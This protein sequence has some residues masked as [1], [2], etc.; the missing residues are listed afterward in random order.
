[1]HYYERN[2]AEIKHEYT[3]FLIHIISPLIYEGIK[4]MYKKAVET[5]LKFKELAKQN[6]NVNN[7]GILKLFQHFLKNIPTLN[8]TLIES[9]MIRIRD[10]SKHAD[11]FEKLIKAV[12]KSHIIL[13]TF[14][15]SGKKCK[16][17]NDKIHEQIDIKMFI[18]KIYIE[19]A[20]QIYNSPELFWHEFSS[21]EI[22]RNQRECM[23]IINKAINL[24]IKESIPM[25][26]VLTEFLK[27]DYIEETYQQKIDNIKNMLNKN[28]E[29]NINYFDDDD[30]KDEKDD[31][32][33]ESFQVRPPHS[34]SDIVETKNDNWNLTTWVK[35]A[36]RYSKGMGNE[37]KID[38]Y[39]YNA[40]PTIPLPEGQLFF[41]NNTKFD[42]ECCPATYSSSRG[43]ACLS[44]PQYNHL[45][46]RGG[47]NTPPKNTNTSYFNEF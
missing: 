25:N 38:S 18:H 4:S 42:S 3:D 20:R 35:N 37:N 1:M 40:G 41:F 15:A 29:D 14:N 33:T 6:A 31:D 39:K 27:N 24:A 2:I 26:D 30:K 16:L 36:Q 43:C 45:M 34:Y 47:N 5:D 44:Q 13:L 46:M 22:K 17:I 10:G 23:N 8:D 21:V 12:I 11:I 9:E 32:K 28:A 19:S 7:P